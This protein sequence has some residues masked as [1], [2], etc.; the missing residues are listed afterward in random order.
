VLLLHGGTDSWRSFETL[1]PHLPPD[2]HVLVPSQ[3][4]H[5]GS[6]KPAQGYRTRDF[7]ADAA[8]LIEVLGLAPAVVVGHSMGAANAMR[9]AIDRPELVQGL[10]GMGAFARSRIARFR[11]LSI[12]A[13]GSGAACAGRRLPAQHADATGGQ[14]FVQA[15]VAQSLAVPASGGVRRSARGRFSQNVGQIGVPIAASAGAADAYVTASDT[16]ALLRAIRGASEQTWEGLGHAPHWEDPGRVARAMV[17]FVA[18][19]RAAAVAA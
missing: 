19:L 15:M 10:I 11:A 13:A 5:G 9:M 17:G 6:D 4:G 16:E 3:R 1:L 14:P 7:A 2:W 12:A 18:R 8:R